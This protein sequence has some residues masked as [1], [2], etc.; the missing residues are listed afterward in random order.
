MFA[1]QAETKGNQMILTV[2]KMPEN[3]IEISF[4]QGSWYQINLFNSAGIP[5][6]PFRIIVQGAR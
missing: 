3:P 6:I 2:E 4:A 1:F 5:A